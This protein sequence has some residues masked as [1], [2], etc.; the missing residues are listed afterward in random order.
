VKVKKEVKVGLLVTSALVALIYGVNYLKGVDMFTGVHTYYALYSRVDGLTPSGDVLLNGVKVGQV[1]RIDFLKDRSGNIV[2]TI[3]VRKDVFISKGSTARIVSSDL[4]GG[5]AVEILL[6]SDKNPASPGDTLF[7]DMQTTLSDQM[8]PIKDRA[9]SLL[10]SLDTLAVSLNQV[11]NDQNRKNLNSGLEN[12]EKSLANLESIS[13]SVDNMLSSDQGKLKRMIDNLESISSNMRNNNDE[14]TNALENF[15]DISDTLAAANLSTT[16]ANTSKAMERF[17]DVM[18]KINK[19][20]GTIGQLMTN[21]SLYQAIEKSAKDLD[22][23]IVDLKENPKRYVHF[24]V[25]G[26]K[27]KKEKK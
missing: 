2:A 20:E 12:L 27:D 7:S 5:R 17:S 26:K 4:L 23:L 13:G 19:G 15:S 25:F 9:E 11:F 24:S 10:A 8:L 3:Q 6:G 18:N 22:M 14:L 1:R 21:D 16:I